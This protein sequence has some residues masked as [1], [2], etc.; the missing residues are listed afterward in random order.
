[1]KRRILTGLLL[2]VFLLGACAAGGTAA[3]RESSDAA[4]EQEGQPQ[5]QS[6]E[7]SA[8][9]MADGLG[10]RY[11]FTDDDGAEIRFDKPFERIVCLYS[12]HTENLFVLGAGGR[13][14]GGHS[15]SVYP[16]EAAFLPVFDYNGDVERVIAAEPDLVLIRPFISRRVPEYVEQLRQAGITVVSLYPDT[17]EAFPEYIRKLAMMTGTEEE[18]E[19]QLELMDDRLGSIKQQTETVTDRQT[20]FFEST[21]T[22]IRTVTDGSMPG[23]AIVM[24]G[25]V[26]LAA[27]AESSADGSSIAEFGVEKV[28]SHAEDI[29]VYV[30]QRGAMNSGGNLQS[31]SER[32][33]YDT[34]RA[35]REGRVYLINEKLISSPT[36][37][38]DKGVRE[39][40][41]FL[42]PELMDDLSGYEDSRVMTKRDFANIVVRAGHVPV[43][44]PSSS[45]YYQT[46]QKGHTYGL[47]EDAGWEDPD[48]D[49]IE[50]AVHAGYVE[51][52]MVD[53]KEYF[54]PDQAVTREELARALFLMGDFENQEEHVAISDLGETGHGRI[55]QI[56]VDCGVFELSGGKFEPG[57]I[58]GCDE[59]VRCFEFLK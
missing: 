21:E 15:T 12:A 14:I 54:H 18:A 24:A 22:N 45:K 59:A 28:L 33:G 52:D 2:A 16:P 7:Q 30:S 35:V 51:W 41:R 25:G 36:F 49:Y 11:R 20:V 31:I 34:I 55:V 10:E 50:T 6:R 39:L 26:S 9:R 5:E 40:A 23:L 13:V 47:F 29:D 4:L 27:G 37:R 53:G 8:G 19:R 42:Y 58:V 43:Y 3:A 38:Y 48:F 44:V 17:Y 46:A 57:R 56:L 1:M 32:P